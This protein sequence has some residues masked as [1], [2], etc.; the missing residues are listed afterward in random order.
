ME[1]GEEGER[2]LRREQIG[3]LT[4]GWKGIDLGLKSRRANSSC[5]ANA[6]P[7]I[8]LLGIYH[9]WRRAGARLPVCV[10]WKANA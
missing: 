7:M 6:F 3:D 4:A 8:Y 1:G 9:V 5:A 10:G 2:E